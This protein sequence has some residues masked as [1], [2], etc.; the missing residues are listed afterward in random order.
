MS[1]EVLARR[2]EITGQEPLLAIIEESV[3]VKSLHAKKSVPAVNRMVLSPRTNVN[4][5]DYA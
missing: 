4:A 5:T 2:D 3:I 1:K